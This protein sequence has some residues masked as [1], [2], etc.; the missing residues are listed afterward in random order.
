MRR[1][2]FNCHPEQR[3]GSLSRFKGFFTAFRMT[4]FAILLFPV[5]ASAA[6]AGFVPSTGIWFSR[7][8]FSPNETVRVY[9]AIFNNEYKDFSGTV[10]F[11]DN[12]AVIDSVL[13][14]NLAREQAEQVRVFWQPTEGRHTISARF[15]SAQATDDQGRTLTISIDAINSQAGLPLTISPGAE[16][17]PS[18][19]ESGTEKGLIGSTIVS[20]EKKDGAF[21]IV[22]PEQR[23]VLGE[24]VSPSDNDPVALAT[25]SAP[26][27]TSPLSET[28]LFAKNRAALEAARS[29]VATVTTT[30]NSINQAYTATKDVVEQGKKVFDQGQK[31]YEKMKAVW[32]KTQPYLDMAKPWW[33]KLSNNNEPKRLAIIF[34]VVVVV[35]LSWRWNS[36]RRSYYDR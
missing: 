23:A 21:A 5:V 15:S 3:E 28:D 26:E 27:P 11:Y 30:A 19:V 33:N 12:N 17:A 29:A 7:T 32:V 20:V 25:V 22:A 13:V 24:K 36:R 18:T 9:T 10:V 2:F 8:A 34:G 14:K 16:V 6:A 1:I 31:F 4:V 35:Y